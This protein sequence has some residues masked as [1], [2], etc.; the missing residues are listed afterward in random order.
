[1]KKTNG[2]S[3]M[4]STLK[5]SIFT[6]VKVEMVTPKIVDGIVAELN[7]RILTERNVTAV[8]SF[9]EIDGHIAANNNYCDLRPLKERYDTDKRILLPSCI[10]TV[11]SAE[12]VMTEKYHKIIGSQRTLC[13]FISIDVSY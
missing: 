7:G 11:I 2:D 3:R 12:S 13:D 5:M 9:V 1:M 10:D 6:S 8:P 4:V